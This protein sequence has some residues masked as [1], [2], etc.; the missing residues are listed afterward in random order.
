MAYKCF[1][2]IVLI[3]LTSQQIWA[4]EFNTAVTVNTP[5]IQSVDR[6]VFDNLEKQIKQ[7]MNNRDWT[8]DEY[9]PEELIELNIV[10]TVNKEKSQTSFEGQIMVQ[11]SRPVYGSGYNSMI[12]QYLDKQF[13]FTYG[14][15]EVLD[16]A[17]NSF[18]SNLTSVLAFYA[19]II[20]GID[21]D[22]FSELGGSDHIDKA[23]NIVNSVPST[24]GATGWTAN[25]TGVA[26]RN[27]FWLVENMLSVRMQDMRRAMY[28]YHL[29][30]VDRLSQL[31]TVPKG[32]GAM[33]SSLETV[34]KSNVAYPSTMWVQLFADFKRDEII[35]AFSIADVRTKRKVHDIMIKLDAT[36]AQEYKALLK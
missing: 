1:G 26:N 12:F 6:K 14:E 21:H 19:Y 35:N 23:Q 27:R 29:L 33:L 15:F 5:K 34:A 25:S 20:L 2:W 11:A 24:A 18:T 31:E 32:L 22:S 30:G 10:I 13:E 28:Q 16:F 3:L 36:H 8:E 17:E 4:Q 9:E 7:F